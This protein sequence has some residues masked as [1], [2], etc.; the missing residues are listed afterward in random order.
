MLLDPGEERLQQLHK[1]QLE[2]ENSMHEMFRLIAA[3]DLEKADILDKERVDPGFNA[4]SDMITN[5]SAI[6][7]E[8]ANQAQRK[9]G[10][11]TTLVIIAA[12]IMVGSLILRFQKMQLRAKLIAVEQKVLRQSEERYRT[13]I[14]TAHDLIWTLNNEGN[15]TFFNRRSEETSGYKISE[16]SVKVLPL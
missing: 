11:D 10:I 4:L 5:T 15:F 2:F 7:S 1:A 3:G 14:E 9:A 6:Y 16:W 13:I 12:G 8:R